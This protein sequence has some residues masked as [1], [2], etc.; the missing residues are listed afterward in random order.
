MLQL[1][2]H[3]LPNLKRYRELGSSQTLN[4]FTSWKVKRRKFAVPG[5]HWYVIFKCIFV[6]QSTSGGVF[7][8]FARQASCEWN[9]DII[10]SWPSENYL[11]SQNTEISHHLF[12]AFPETELTSPWK[13][14][15]DSNT[16]ERKF[17]ESMKIEH[18][19]ADKQ[20]TMGLMLE[21]PHIS[22]SSVPVV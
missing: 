10:S 20:S 17:W 12:A 8:S 21:S 11:Y 15:K 5:K 18:I 22:L 19:E 6:N 13:N 4:C 14:M 7:F 1:F 16:P 9:P 3:C 2:E